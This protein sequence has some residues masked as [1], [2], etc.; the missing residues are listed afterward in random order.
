MGRNISRPVS[1]G[2]EYRINRNTY[3]VVGV[4]PE[5]ATIELLGNGYQFHAAPDWQ[6]VAKGMRWVESEWVRQSRLSAYNNNPLSA[7]DRRYEGTVGSG[8]Y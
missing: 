1:L 2:A 7:W 8:D 5:Y 6:S 3:K 4:T